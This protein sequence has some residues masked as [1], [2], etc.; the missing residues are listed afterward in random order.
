M[1]GSAGFV[2]TEGTMVE[3]R[4]SGL[5]QFSSTVDHRDGVAVVRII[6]ELDLHAVSPLRQSLDE[7]VSAAVGSPKVVVD[8]TGLTFMDS[9]GLGALV[10]TQKKVGVLDGSFGVVCAGGP[11]SRLLEITGLTDV[12]R[13]SDTVDAAVA[14]AL[15]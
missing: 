2:R 13:V 12:L 6:G 15:D 7:V 8:L 5:G 4:G 3:T 9:T 10:M 1:R 14:R 11:V